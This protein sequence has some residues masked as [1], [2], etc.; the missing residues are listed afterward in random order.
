MRIEYLCAAIV[1][2]SV[3]VVGKVR[4]NRCNSNPSR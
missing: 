1:F 4:R 3:V 2:T